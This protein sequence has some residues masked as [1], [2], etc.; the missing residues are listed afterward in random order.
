MFEFQ[1]FDWEAAVREIDVA[2]ETSN[3]S[4]SSSNHQR[5][6]KKPLATKQSKLDKFFTNA[7]P[8]PQPQPQRQSPPSPT[9][10]FELE[11]ESCYVQIDTEAAKTWIYPSN[12]I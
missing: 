11:E 12:L 8:R 5:N 9:P 7:P 2:C 10:G 6:S 4:T 3:V 1:E